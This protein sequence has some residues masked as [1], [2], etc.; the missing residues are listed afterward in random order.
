MS[1]GL[2]SG[3]GKYIY[4]GTECA[5]GICNSIISY[6]ASEMGCKFFGHYYGVGPSNVVFLG[7]DLYRDPEHAAGTLAGFG[8]SWAASAWAGAKIGAVC[9]GVIGAVAGAVIGFCVGTVVSYCVNEL[10]DS[11]R[12]CSG[13]FSWRSPGGSGGPGGVEFRKINL[14]KGFTEAQVILSRNCNIF[15]ETY[16][17]KLTRTA[18]NSICLPNFRNRSMNE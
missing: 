5:I 8:A 10:T 12:S 4:Q 11:Y 1:S 13:I 3:V 18:F 15:F 7:I 16:N 2:D 6:G 17:E 14:I 9:G